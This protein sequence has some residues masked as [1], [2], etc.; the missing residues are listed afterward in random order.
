MFE[1]IVNEC[2]CCCILLRCG[3]SVTS[4]YFVQI[5]LQVFFFFYFCKLPTDIAE[6]LNKFLILFNT[7]E[8][9]L[10]SYVCI[11]FILFLELGSEEDKISL[12]FL[13]FRLK[14]NKQRICISCLQ[15]VHFFCYFFFEHFACSMVPK[16]MLLK[17]I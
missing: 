15:N 11:Y 9:L 16:C 6:N 14:Q 2:L 1:S 8:P 10:C 7:L 12:Q 13:A 5:M 17:I 3:S 4:V